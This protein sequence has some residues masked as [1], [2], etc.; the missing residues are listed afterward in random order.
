MNY[1]FV[2]ALCPTFRHPK[3]LANSVALW[4]LQDYPPE[5]RWMMILDDDPTFVSQSVGGERWVLESHPNRFPSISDKYNYLLGRVPVETEII[6]VW[7]D[8]DIY[9]P[10]YVSAHANALRNA[11]YSKPNVILTD[12]LSTPSTLRITQ[13]SAVGRFHS[14]IGARRDLLTSVGGWPDT[15]RADFDQQL[16]SSLLKEA[17]GHATVPWDEQNIQFIYRWHSGAAHCQ[18]TMRSPDDE[19]WYERGEKAYAKV[20]FVG[21]LVPKLDEF[22]TRM[23]DKYRRKDWADVR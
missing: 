11:K 17:N 13:E 18:S 22:T 5:R 3:L 10:G 4:N 16:M 23:L 15:K 12:Y 19:T 9:L 20:P 8:D 6:L 1:P 14:T 21:R 7:E 2:T